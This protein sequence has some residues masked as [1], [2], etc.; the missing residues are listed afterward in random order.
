M[1]LGFEKFR[2][3]SD[4]EWIETIVRS[5]REP[6]ID[7]VVFPGFPSDDLQAMVV[8]SSN[9]HAIREAGSFYKHIKASYAH[10]TGT[11]LTDAVTLDFGIGWGR[12]AR[13]FARDAG[14]G[15][16][17]GVDPLQLM[18]EVCR[19]TRVPAS[20]S[21]NQ[22]EGL[23]PFRDGI[24]DLVYA[25]SVFTHLPENV[26]LHWIDELY[27]V[28]RPGGVVVMTVEPPRFIDFCRSITDAQAERSNWHKFL[29]DR[30]SEM[31]DAEQQ[32]AEGGLFTSLLVVVPIYLLLCMAM[33]SFLKGT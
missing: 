4:D 22:P 9:E 12:I 32:A 10:A 19:E 8:G 21:I 2:G 7:G 18:V 24:F 14:I 31:P 15:R 25:F 20:I 13:L 6:L 16:L 23:L 17:Y 30:I 1:A 26:S 3:L 28:T 33:P 11:E 5:I 27:R 29:R